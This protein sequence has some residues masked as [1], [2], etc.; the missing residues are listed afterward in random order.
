MLL[1]RMTDIANSI[2][3]L[4]LFNANIK[5]LFRNFKKSLHIDTRFAASKSIGRVR[6]IAIQLNNTIERNI[7]SLLDEKGF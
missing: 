3:S 1:N 5:S 4:T 6:N 2:T 7:V